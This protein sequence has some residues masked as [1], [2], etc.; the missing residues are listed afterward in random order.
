MTSEHLGC[1]HPFDLHIMVA[2]QG[3]PMGGGIMLCPVL[4]CRCLSTWGVGPGSEPP[5]VPPDEEIAR[6]QIAVQTGEM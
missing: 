2:T 6:I 5:P 3:S 4:E 1:T